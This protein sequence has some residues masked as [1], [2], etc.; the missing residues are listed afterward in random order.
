[1]QFWPA[2]SSPEKLEYG[3][4]HFRYGIIGGSKS[5]NGQ[6]LAVDD[7][8]GEVPFDEVA[9]HSPLFVFQVNE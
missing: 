6:A 7:E 5:G 9:Q 4:L 2:S 8:F 3:L 1:M